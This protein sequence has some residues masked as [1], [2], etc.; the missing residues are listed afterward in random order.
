M[1]LGKYGKFWMATIAVLVSWVT[2]VSKPPVQITSL[3]VIV[4]VTG[5]IQAVT[6]LLL[7]NF[8]GWIWK[9]VGNLL[10]GLVGW[11][12]LIGN[13]APSGVS[14]TEWAVLLTIA[15]GAFGVYTVSN[16][17]TSDPVPV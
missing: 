4:G 8:S 6:T 2:L 14:A 1:N 15:A 3:E 13:S 12:V 17:K 9:A 16:A 11:F 5:I 7:P 10:T